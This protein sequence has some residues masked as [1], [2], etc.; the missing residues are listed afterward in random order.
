MLFLR[1][2][3][4]VHIELLFRN[5]PAKV[6][7]LTFFGLVCRGHSR[8]WIWRFWGAPIFRPEVPNPLKKTFWGLWTEDRGAPKKDAKNLIQP[9]QIQ[10][11]ILGP[12]SKQV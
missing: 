6:H 2:T 3:S 5:A 11:P 12:L 10:P 7:E 8:G 1:K 9:R 4:T